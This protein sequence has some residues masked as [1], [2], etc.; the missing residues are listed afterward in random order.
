MLHTRVAS[1]HRYNNVCLYADEVRVGCTPADLT[2]AP[3]VINIKDY[4]DSESPVIASKYRIMFENDDNKICS[5]IEEIYVQY[6]DVTDNFS[7]SGKITNL[8]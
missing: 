1:R 7:T 4:T 5:Q 8:A 6:L 2:E 3:S